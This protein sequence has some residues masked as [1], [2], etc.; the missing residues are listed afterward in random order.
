MSLELA[1]EQELRNIGRS[2]RVD[3]ARKVGRILSRR[4]ETSDAEDA[5]A[6]ARILVEDAS[7]SVREAL[8]LELRN[9]SFL[10]RDIVS[11]LSRDIEQISLP[12]LLASEAIDDEFLEQIVRGGDAKAQTVVARRGSLSEAVSYAISDVG[13]LGAVSELVGNN[14]AEFSERVHTRV[15]DRF[16]EEQT[17]IEALVARADFPATLIERV[18]FKV[19]KRY[20][21]YLNEKF[22][23]ST[24]YSSYLMSLAKRHVFSKTLEMA[25]LGEIRNYME[26][27]HASR[28]LVS[29]VVLGYL[30]NDNIRQFNMALA[31][32]LNRPYEQVEVV[33]ARRDKA[34]MARLLDAAGFSK[35][36]V[37]VLLIAYER[38][39]SQL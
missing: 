21:E 11:T 1:D 36:V 30:Q 24:D 20:S 3:I 37:G 25:P 23:L 26:Q 4:P 6:L 2:A 13:E 10:P 15:V 29:D 7:V 17:L 9:C 22:D 18:I 38:L 33:V 39:I 35:S 27:L 5:L 14:D 12:F 31:I 8:S 32:L 16:P 34:L 19:S 28:G